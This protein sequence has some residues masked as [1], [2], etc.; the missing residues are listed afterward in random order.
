MCTLRGGSKGGL[1]APAPLQLMHQWKYEEGEEEE[2]V[3]ERRKIERERGRR[4][5]DEPSL[6]LFC[7]RHW[8]K[9]L[10]MDMEAMNPWC[11]R[12]NKNGKKEGYSVY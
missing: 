7:I 6:I 9:K 10:V 4:R 11:N 8:A 1:G 2:E 12:E 3:E 5:R